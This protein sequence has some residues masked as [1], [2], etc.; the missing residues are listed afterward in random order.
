VWREA[1]PLSAFAE[2]IAGSA[3]PRV[4]WLTQYAC[5]LEAEPNRYAICVNFDDIR[6]RPMAGDT[7]HVRRT[8]GDQYEDTIRVVRVADGRLRL[9]LEGAADIDYSMPVQAGVDVEIRGLVVAF[10][11]AVPF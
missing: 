8:R 10:Y 7:V 9:Q 11:Q 5:R 2:R 1:P 6:S 3:D 4:A